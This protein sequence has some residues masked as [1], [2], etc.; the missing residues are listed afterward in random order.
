MRVVAAAV[1]AMAG[2]ASTAGR[3]GGATDSGY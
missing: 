3:T 2:G 1:A